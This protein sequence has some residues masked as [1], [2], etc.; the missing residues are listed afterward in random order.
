MKTRVLVLGIALAIGCSDEKSSKIATV[1]PYPTCTD[2]SHS[3][4]VVASI[5]VPQSSADRTTYG[6]DLDGNGE[7][8]NQLGRVLMGLKQA[9]MD[10]NVQDAVDKAFMNGTI[11]VLFDVIYKPTLSDATTAGIKTLI[12]THDMSDGQMAPAYYTSGTA[13]FMVG[14]ALSTTGAGF[15]GGVRAGNADFGP[16]AL[17]LQLPLVPDSPPLQL[18]LIQSE[19]SAQI[20]PAGMMNG[21]LCGAI[22]ADQI[23][24]TILPNV[25]GLLS[26]EIKKGGDAADTIKGLFDVDMSCNTDPACKATAPATPACGCITTA[27]VAGN[28]IV[29]TLLGPDL[30]LDPAKHNPFVP[31]NDQDYQK[32]ALSIG[33]GFTATKA[34]IS[35]L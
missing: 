6:C 14:Q 24:T 28:S 13:K 12:G 35:G 15:G 1:K 4:Y 27:E 32:D 22:P 34:Q 31:P 21:V 7:V 8:D 3:Q 16:G 11:N 23:M 17:L 18:N 10:V 33:L 25:A 5:K 9:S 29:K 30:D 2:C 20:T 19:V 26:A